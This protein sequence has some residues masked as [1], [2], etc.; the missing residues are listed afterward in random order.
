MNI[1]ITIR[2]ITKCIT[3]NRKLVDRTDCVHNVVLSYW[4]P[5][6]RRRG[7]GD[8]ETETESRRRRN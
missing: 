5:L 2:Q 8:E 6:G 7:G 1:V 3:N 4:G